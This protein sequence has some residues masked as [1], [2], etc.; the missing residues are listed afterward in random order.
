MIRERRGVG[1][2]R[3]KAAGNSEGEPGGKIENDR[4][5]ERDGAWKRKGRAEA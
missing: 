5:T 1:M 2:M 4:G 3:T